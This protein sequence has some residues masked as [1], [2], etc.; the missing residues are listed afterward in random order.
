[1]KRAAIDGATRFQRV[2][3]VDLPCIA[4][5]IIITLILNAGNI[6][7]LGFEK[8]YLMQN[9]LNY[10]TSEIIATYVYKT[11]IEQAQIQFFY[12]RGVV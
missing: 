7:S 9:A 2:I 4:P 5:T 6:L 8:A 10:N 12:S 3:H 11:G 1:M